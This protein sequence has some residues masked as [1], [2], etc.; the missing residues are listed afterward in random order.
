MKF[1]ET[2]VA[3]ANLSTKQYYMVVNSAARLADIAGSGAIVAG[4]LQNKPESGQHAEVVVLGKSKVKAGGTITAGQVF[5]S[6]ASGSA[7][8]VTSGL[9][10]AGLAITGVASGGIFDAIIGPGGYKG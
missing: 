1:E 6:D 4:V 8:A 10:I 2:F 7:T 3:N 9:W 5:M